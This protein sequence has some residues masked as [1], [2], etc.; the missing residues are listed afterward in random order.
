MLGEPGFPLHKI[1]HGTLQEQ[2]KLGR[3]MRL[4]QVRQFMR[5]EILRNTRR[6]SAALN[7]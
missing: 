7:R 5:L 2:P 4:M 3:V 1:R 6:M